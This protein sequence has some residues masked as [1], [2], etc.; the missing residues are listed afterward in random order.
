MGGTFLHQTADKTKRLWA[1]LISLVIAETILENSIIGR[2]KITKDQNKFV[3]E[4]EFILSGRTCKRRSSSSSLKT[5]HYW[6]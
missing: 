3:K 5:E 2:N 6:K 4:D 1:I